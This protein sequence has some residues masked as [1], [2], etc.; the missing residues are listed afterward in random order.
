ME[1]KHLDLTQPIENTGHRPAAILW[2][3]LPEIDDEDIES[4]SI[5]ANF[6]QIATDHKGIVHHRGDGVTAVFGIPNAAEDDALRATQAALQMK[7]YALQEGTAVCVAVSYAHITIQQSDGAADTLNIAGEAIDQARTL[8][9]ATPPLT[10]LVTENVHLATTY[11]FTYQSRTIKRFTNHI[12]ELLAPKEETTTFRGLPGAR[13]RY[14]GRHASLQG[15]LSMAQNLENNLGGIVWIEGEAGIG[16][17]RLMSEFKTAVNEQTSAIIWTGNCAPQHA[18]HAFSLFSDLLANIFDIQPTDSN[19]RRQ[20]KLNDG[21]QNWPRDA[22]ATRPYLETLMGITPADKQFPHMQPEQLRQQ[23]FVAMRRLLMTLVK[24]QPIILV[25]DDLHWIDP[26]SAELLRFI[27]TIV[28][29]EP[30]LFICAQR[31]QGADAPNDRLLQIQS[32]LPGQ[33]NRLHLE[34]LSD[35]DSRQLLH[36]LL[37]AGDIPKTFESSAIE[38]CEGNPYF[39]EEFV[40]MFIEQGHLYQKDGQWYMTLSPAQLQEMIPISLDT[41][42]H[43]RLDALPTDLRQ[44]I[45]FAAVIG[46]QF[47]TNLLQEVSESAH[48]QQALFRLSQRLMVSRTAVPQRW[49]FNHN[50]FQTIAYQSIPNEQQQA[51]HAQVA[52][53]L[54]ADTHDQETD[55]AKDLAY[56][57]SRAHEYE[58]ATPYLLLAGEKAVRHY[59]NEEAVEHFQQANEYMAQLTHRPMQWQWQVALGLGD[60]YQNMGQFAESMTVLEK[61]IPLTKSNPVLKVQYPSLLR[62]LGETSRKQGLYDQAQEFLNNAQAQLGEPHTASQAEEAAHITIEMAW[63][64][65]HQGEYEMAEQACQ[66]AIAYANEFD[67]QNELARAENLLGGIYYQGGNWQAAMQHTTRALALREQLGYSWLV[68]SSYGNLGILA[69][70]I[71]NWPKAI[72]YFQRSL[73]M[74]QESGDVQGVALT[75]NNLGLA[76]LGQGKLREA[77]H[78]YRQSLTTAKLFNMVYYLANACIGLAHALVLQGNVAESEKTINLGLEQAQE[79]GSQSLVAEVYCVQAE[80]RILQTQYDEALSISQSAAHLAAEIGEWSVE[81]ERMASSS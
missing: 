50:L 3:D 80:L 53:A 71:G 17:S 52:I 59:A 76:F 77:E 39:L 30:V 51:L 74:R 58:R 49:Q 32:L 43:S 29:S 8:A 26:V 38:R 61:M 56:H 6:A 28:V 54:E 2:L 37:L 12:W 65:F 9:L 16:K 35:A 45:Q 23:T 46:Q 33:T 69:Y 67:C 18:N 25:L 75:H 7:Q 55:R 21:I 40:R 62:R 36:E 81:V 41:L 63:A 22:Q 44:M 72:D 10:I 14:I 13:T 27:A 68:A 70:D 66:R 60:A 1:F 78:H 64:H 79:T 31:L 4:S 19:Q 57:L 48:V 34:K 24:K 20:K 15:M 73:A 11:A 5:V 47:D 42:I